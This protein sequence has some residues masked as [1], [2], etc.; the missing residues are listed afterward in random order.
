MPRTRILV[1]T[2]SVPWPANSGEKMRSL[3]MVRG[4]AGVGDVTVVAFVGEHEDPSLSIREGVEVRAVDERQRGP[5]SLLA[6][7][8]RHRSI[9]VGKWAHRAFASAVREELLKG[10]DVIVVEHVQ[11]TQYVPRAL[12]DSVV[13]VLDMHNVESQL[14]RRLGRTTRWPK[15]WIYPVEAAA[16]KRLERRAVRRFDHVYVVSNAD[17][18]TLRLE[19]GR[20]DVEVIPNAIDPAAAPTDQPLEPT[21]CFV[22]VMS[23]EPNALAAVNLATKVWPRVLE[24]LPQAKLFIVGREPTAAVQAL[25]NEN[26]VVTGTVTDLGAWYERS[27]IA[28]APLLAGGG[29]RLKILEALTHGRPVVAT[30]VGAE[31]LDDLVGRGVLV[32]QTTEELAGLIVDLLSD[33]EASARLGLAGAEA[34]RTDYSWAGATQPLRRLV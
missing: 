21:A 4:L 10:V 19:T 11:L 28:L 17:R 27:R 29:S 3:G 8:V 32:G 6:S 25:A 7:S 31:G 26:I 22:G 14:T 16:L 20:S 13:T 15:R 23:W 2:K 18:E 5:L 34:V 12:P 33:R 24:D 1:L 30:R 9:T